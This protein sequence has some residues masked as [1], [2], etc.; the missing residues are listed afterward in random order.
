[1][2]YPADNHNALLFNKIGSYESLK[3][4][5]TFKAFPYSCII[6]YFTFFVNPEYEQ[7][8]LPDELVGKK[9]TR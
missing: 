2:A 6:Y 5:A 8:F 1:M 9:Y 7:Q 4:L 3:G